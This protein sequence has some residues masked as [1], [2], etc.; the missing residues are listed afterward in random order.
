MEKHRIAL[1][2]EVNLYLSLYC[3]FFL[4]NFQR[5]ELLE[6]LSKVQVSNEELKQFASVAEMQTGKFKRLVKFIT[7]HL[8]EIIQ[9]LNI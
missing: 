2:A 8:I 7:T 1:V 9:D 3:D 6:S 4:H 5:A